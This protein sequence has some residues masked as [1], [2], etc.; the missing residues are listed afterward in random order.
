M[1]YLNDY[2][3]A[4][5]T[6]LPRRPFRIYSGDLRLT[7]K[8]FWII[9]HKYATSET[10]E[11]AKYCVVA[12]YG[13]SFYLLVLIQFGDRA[14]SHI[15]HGLNFHGCCVKT[16]ILWQLHSNSYAHRFAHFSSL[17]TGVFGYAVGVFTGLF[18]DSVAVLDEGKKCPPG[19]EWMQC[20]MGA[21]SCMDLT[22]DL[23]RNCTPGCRCP[24]GTVQQVNGWQEY[25]HT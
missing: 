3:R 4:I 5:Q 2:F 17:Q 11:R 12:L 10:S 7:L 13:V 25:T 23:S 20:M 22:L 9:C 18:S 19:Q 21:V 24:Q 16:Q 1:Q 6:Q 15:A 14:L 8:S